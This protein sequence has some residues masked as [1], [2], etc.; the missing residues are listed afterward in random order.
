MLSKFPMAI[1]R[2]D[3]ATFDFSLST[4]FFWKQANIFLFFSIIS[5]HIQRR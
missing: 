1:S 4:W 3:K 5:L 2:D